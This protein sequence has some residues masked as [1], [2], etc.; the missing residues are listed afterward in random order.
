[1]LYDASVHTYY[2]YLDVVNLQNRDEH[3]ENIR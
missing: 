1:L 3:I 2:V